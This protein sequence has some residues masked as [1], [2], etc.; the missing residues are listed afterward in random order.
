[1]KA[2]LCALLVAGAFAGP[3]TGQERPEDRVPSRAD[4]T[5]PLT[6]TLDEALDY[7]AGANPTLRQATN[8]AT[9]NAAESRSLWFTQL[10]PSASLT[11]FETGFTGNLRRRALDNFGNP[12]PNP[13]AEWN[14]FSST[15]HR[16]GL[17][18]TLQGPSLLQAHRTQGLTNRD[19]ELAVRGVLSDVQAEVQRLY[20][21]ALEQRA[22]MQAEEALIEARRIDL[23][24][25]QRLFQL[26][27]RTRVDVLSA[28]LQLE[29]Q[30]LAHQ[31]QE[32]AYQRALLALRTAMGL[33]EARP[34]ELEDEPLPLFDPVGLNADVLLARA[35]EVNPGL[36]RSDVAMRSSEVAL[37][38]RRADWWP[39]IDLGM[40]VFKVA[41]EPFGEALF[42]PPGTSELESQFYVQLSF[43][44]L[45]GYF[46]S[47]V[48]RDRAAVELQNDREL[49]RQ[50]RLELEEAIRGALLDLEN[51]W[52][53]L[54][55]S[56][57][58]LVIAEEALRLAREEYRLG[59]RTFSDLRDSF[60]QEADTR[61][62]VIT[63]RHRFVDALLTLEA[64][65]G[66]PVR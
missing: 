41:Y 8:T 3:V 23:D 32:S 13:G 25:A 11:L 50:A 51:E 34:L 47:Q 57:R 46:Q 17:N 10:L 24:V 4:P 15:S 1:M 31:Q 59:T 9:L 29:Q 61:R 5:D 20:M 53:S 28:E 6:L 21:D 14:Y 7:A 2:L 63:T 43:P 26:A 33:S 19:R 48:E 52:A 62:G 64:A 37:A 22:L 27:L 55:L 36:L 30:R 60:Q 56:E 12:I 35:S 44:I 66:A 49:D 45:N 16:F 18:W 54:Q 39:Q 40:S 42:E 38:R 65:V 58:S